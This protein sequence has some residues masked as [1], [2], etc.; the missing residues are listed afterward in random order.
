MEE[1]SVEESMPSK[2]R[3]LSGRKLLFVYLGT[4]I[5]EFNLTVDTEYVTTIFNWNSM[6]EE[7]VTLRDA[8]GT[9]YKVINRDLQSI[10]HHFKLKEKDFLTG[11][12]VSDDDRKLFIY[13][14]TRTISYSN[15][16]LS[17]FAPLTDISEK[18]SFVHPCQN[19]EC[20]GTYLPYFFPSDQCR[21]TIAFH[22]FPDNHP[23]HG[24]LSNMSDEKAGNLMENDW[25]KRLHH[26]FNSKKIS[27]QYTAEMNADEVNKLNKLPQQLKI[28]KVLLFRGAPDLI[29]NIE[30]HPGLVTCTGVQGSSNDSSCRPSEDNN[31]DDSC[32][33]CE[34]DSPDEL[35]R[36]QMGHQMK[37]KSYEPAS[38]QPQKVGELVAAMHAALCCKALRKYQN[39]TEFNCL[40]AH[41]LFVHRALG[42]VRV[43]V[44]LSKTSKMKIFSEL[45]VSGVVPP[46]YFCSAIKYFINILQEP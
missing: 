1:E 20:Y 36:M 2:K 13:S 8:S 21:H 31:S 43:V 27:C 32:S 30:K 14:Y 37:T 15:V 41:G 45:L 33:S 40:Q 42:L 46:G 9:S 11:Q 25:T 24:L 38:F 5:V 35:V 7:D 39:M 12:F 23:L 28:A 6:V 10:Q 34:D 4:R 44:T 29:L 19:A 18:T 26:C 3:K 17:Y 16:K 22:D